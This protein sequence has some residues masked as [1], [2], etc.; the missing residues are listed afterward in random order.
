M[1]RSLASLFSFF[2][3]LIQPGYAVDLIPIDLTVI[4]QTLRVQVQGGEFDESRSG[5]SEVAIDW[6]ET[7]AFDASGTASATE[8]DG[9]L[10]FHFE[11][12][13]TVSDTQR[14]S[15][16]SQ[17]IH[18]IEFNVPDVGDA[19]TTVFLRVQES[20]STAVGLTMPPQLSL[21]TDVAWYE[22]TILGSSVRARTENVGVCS[23]DDEC[24]PIITQTLIPGDRVQ[25][26]LQSH[27]SCVALPGSGSYDA[28]YTVDLFAVPPPSTSRGQGRCNAQPELPG[29]P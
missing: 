15:V 29:C 6:I 5:T 28:T 13:F 11:G 14:K 18:L 8:I 2:L 20:S 25:M 21:E 9:R 12:A 23:D 1:S 4:S 22:S 16:G 26:P 24:A 27:T 7:S 10:V 19:M 17:G 3:V